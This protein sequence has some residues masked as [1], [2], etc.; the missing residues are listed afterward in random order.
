MNIKIL[1]DNQAK[2]GFR[3]GWG[4]SAL[5]DN[6]TLFDMGE[7]AEALLTN[8]QVFGIEPD[9]IQ[10]VVLSHEDWDHVGGIAILKQCGPVTVYVPASFSKA[11]KNEINGLNSAANLIEIRNAQEVEPN[12][13]VTPQLGTV[14]KEISLAVRSPKGLV[15]V[16]GCSHPGLD[17]IMARASEYGRIY[18]V[19]GGFHGFSKLK[20]LADVPV[21]VPTH[22]TQ[23]KQE[24]LD[25]YPKQ[26]RSVAAGT[27]IRVQETL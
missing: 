3:S 6:S 14:K 26:T 22:C 27:E 21:I 23:K 20:A 24:I 16:V 7:N 4:F 17:K 12:L 13:I 8:L 2:K 11:I 1:Y 18:A 9:Q 10:R 5:I 15:L 19:I 25:M